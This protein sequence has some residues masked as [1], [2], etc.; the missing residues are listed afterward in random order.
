METATSADR[1]TRGIPVQHFIDGLRKLKEDDF[2]GVNGTL[3]YLRENSVDPES[4]DPYLF[5][6]AQHYTRNLIDKTDL[7]EL[8]AICWEVG[9][10]SSIH[11]HQGQNCWMA[12]PIGR[13]AVQNFRLL[14]EDLAAHRCNLVPTNVVEITQANPV[15]VDPLNPV[16]DV[17]NSREWGQRAVSL[18]IYSRPFNSCIVYSV[19]QGSCGEIA[20]S[21][22]S[23]YGK[24][25]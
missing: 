12:A 13:L 25:V 8:L 3:Q 10:G 7:Y 19:E 15:A 9:M 17:R 2:T 5:W 16:H 4:L 1:A 24:L 20:L 18:H 6:N 21:Y 22:T 11:N 23:M 14:S